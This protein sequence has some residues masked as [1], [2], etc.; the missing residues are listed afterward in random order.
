[1]KFSQ[2]KVFKDEDSDFED[3]KPTVSTPVAGD[4]KTFPKKRY[5]ADAKRKGWRL[6]IRNL[7]FKVSQR[8][9]IYFG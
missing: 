8:V 2:R 1:M 5:F 4:E 9:S 6:I 7:P 3:V